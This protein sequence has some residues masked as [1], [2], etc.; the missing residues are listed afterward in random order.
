M[1]NIINA[2]FTILIL[3]DLQ[4]C[5]AV[6]SEWGIRAH[7]D[8][9]RVSPRDDPSHPI[10]GAGFT[11]IFWPHRPREMST[12]AREV[13]SDEQRRLLRITGLMPLDN[14]SNLAPILRTREKASG[15]C[16]AGYVGQAGYGRYAGG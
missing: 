1:T 4:S 6:L 12:C 15:G 3:Y 5:H 10:D 8:A 16:W 11:S 2:R 14:V 9:R 7:S 13:M